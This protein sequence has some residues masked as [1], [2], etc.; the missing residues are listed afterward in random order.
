ME[1]NRWIKRKRY[2]SV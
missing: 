1:V 2:C